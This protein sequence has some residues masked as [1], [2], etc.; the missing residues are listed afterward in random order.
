MKHYQFNSILRN[1]YAGLGL[2]FLANAASALPVGFKESWMTMGEISNDFSDAAVV[3]TFDQKTSFIGAGVKFRW[4]QS[5][6]QV[7]RVNLVEAELGYRLAR[8]NFP[9]AQANIYLQG[10]VGSAGGNFFAGRQTASLVGIQL[11][12]ETRRIYSALRWHGTYA[13][14]FDYTRTSLS[15]GFSFYKTE[16]DEWQPWFVVE[17]TRVGGSA[18]D[19]IE[20]TPYIRFIHKTLFIEAGAPFQKGKSEGLKVNFRYTF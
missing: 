12:Y 19:P 8:W 13:K 18:K 11:D 2:I 1:V 15:G 10:G 6:A 14:D 16:Y 7:R 9:E 3:Y 20:Y 4:Q 17:A 5:P